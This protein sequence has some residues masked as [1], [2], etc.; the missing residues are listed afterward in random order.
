MT[1]V[2]IVSLVGNYSLEYKS[3]I[4]PIYPDNLSFVCVDWS[5]I[6][7]RKKGTGNF[8]SYSFTNENYYPLPCSEL[9]KIRLTNHTTDKS[10]SGHPN[11]EVVCMA[12][13]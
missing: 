3:S 2:Q 7:E 8:T 6:L 4:Y 9:N 5:Y 13:T 10:E 11:V 12:A 1:K